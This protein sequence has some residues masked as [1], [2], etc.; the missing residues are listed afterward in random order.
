[1]SR[2]DTVGEGIDVCT[3]FNRRRKGMNAEATISVILCTKNEADGVKRVIDAVKPYAAEVIVVDGNSTDGTRKLSAEAGARVLKDHGRGKG[4][5]YKVGIEAVTSDIIVF[6]DADGSHDATEIPVLTKPIADGE[7]DVIIGSRHKG[8][9]DEW[10]GDLNTYLRAIGSGFLSIMINAR[11]KSN[12]TDVLN[13]F[14]AVRTSTAKAVPL[15]A[16]DFD[17]EQHMIV[18]YLKHGY[19]V[20]EV[21]SHEFCRAWGESKLP[22]FRK[23][24]LFFWRLFLDYVTGK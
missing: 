10:E 23:A 9:S 19:R 20:T 15:R 14:R 21:R 4:D 18:Q 16:D 12:L 22:T 2:A 5:A 24:Y 3:Y 1:M 6:I 8:G 7:A 13:G 11:W 17:I